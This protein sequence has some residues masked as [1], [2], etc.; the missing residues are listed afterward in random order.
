METNTTYTLELTH[1]ELMILMSGTVKELNNC[2]GEY[3]SPRQDDVMREFWR[4]RF[5][6][7][8]SLNK[9]ISDILY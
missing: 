2:Y 3:T 1:D 5:D 7:A 4:D 9:R 6:S 8:C